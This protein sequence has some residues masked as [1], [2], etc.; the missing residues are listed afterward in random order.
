MS[1]SPIPVQF[2]DADQVP[3]GV[4]GNVIRGPAGANFQPN[5]TGPFSSRSTYDSQ[6]PGFAFLATDSGL[7]FFREGLTAG[8]WSIGIQF[9]ASAAYVHDQASASDT[10]TINHN[11][12][13]RPSVELFDAGS[14]EFDGEISHPTVNQVVVSLTTAVSGFARLT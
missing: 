3:F 5:A 1:D 2:I 6:A 12:G 7:L 11:L 10:W 14:N 9:A 4:L 13:Y 8:G